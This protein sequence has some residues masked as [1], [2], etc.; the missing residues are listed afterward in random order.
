MKQALVTAGPTRAYIDAVRYIANRSTG[1]MGRAVA[2]ALLADAWHVSYLYGEGALRP[3]LTHGGR[4][5]ER[6]L[7]ELRELLPALEEEIRARP[8]DLIVHAMAVLDYAPAESHPG[9]LD[10][11]AKELTLRLVRTPKVVDRL[12]ELAP[13]AI[14]VPFKLGVG[15]PQARLLEEAAAL[16]RRCGAAFVV[17]ND[18][19]RISAHEHPT[20]LVSPDGRVLARRPTREET[21]VAI[22]SL[23]H[24][25]LEREN[26]R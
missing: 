5:S 15:W 9:K 24:G 1:A 2:E 22:V 19:A 11:D 8:P 21:A 6:C 12:R 25:L 23:V 26:R 18:L 10:S 20:M 14:L 17:A 4:L 3:R 13:G 7:G 16:A